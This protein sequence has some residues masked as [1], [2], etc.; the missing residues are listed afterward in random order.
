MDHEKASACHVTDQGMRRYLLADQRM[1]PPVFLGSR[2][3]TESVFKS[4]RA[5][6]LTFCWFLRTQSSGYSIIRSVG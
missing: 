5:A 2:K 1:V 4:E 6:L 3:F